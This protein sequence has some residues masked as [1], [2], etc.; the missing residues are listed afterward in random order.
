MV[1]GEPTIV[2]GDG[3]PSFKVNFGTDPSGFSFSSRWN[4]FHTY[5]FTVPGQT[6]LK[7]LCTLIFF[8]SL[9]AGWVFYM[10][11]FPEVCNTS[12]LI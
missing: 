9:V 4:E 12:N 11:A 8:E 5:K 6:S 3:G 10:T 2:C 7:V 1:E